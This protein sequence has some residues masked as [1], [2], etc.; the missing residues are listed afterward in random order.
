MTTEKSFAGTTEVK[1]FPTGVDWINTSQP[2]S[3]KDL[4]GKIVILD[5]WT[6]CCINCM[7]IIPQLR[8][9]EKRFVEELVVLGI[10]S[11]K[12]PQEKE[13]QNLRKAVLRLG[14]PHPVMNDRDF[15][16]W[17]S[18]GLRS[19][20]TL[21]FIDPQGKI[22]GIH[23]GEI[24]AVGLGAV[25]KDM[26]AEFDQKGWVDRKPLPFQLERPELGPLSFPG[27]VLADEKSNRLFI[28]DSNHHQIVVADLDGQVLSVAGSGDFGMLDGLFAEATF[29]APQ[30]MAL[31]GQD[32]YVADNENH[33]IRK[34]D[35]VAKTV[36]TV[37][38]VGS[39]A[40]Q[41]SDGGDALE[42]ALSSPWDLAH[43]DGML[44]IAMAG[45]HQIWVLDLKKKKILP[46]AGSGAEGL[47]DGPLANAKMAQPSGLSIH[48]DIMYV[49]D[50][51]TSS[52]RAVEL[53]LDGF[54][55]TIV[56]SDLFAFGDVDGMG[57]IVK[58]QH[59]LGVC[60]YQ[61]I[62]YLADTFNSKIKR[63]F[64][65]TKS[66]MAYLGAGKP[67]KQDGPGALASF[68]EPGGLSAAHGKLY[69]ADTNNH[70]IRVADLATSTVSTLEIKGLE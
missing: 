59:P 49:A 36:E 41:H 45:F 52:V 2:V 68:H 51:E 19:W 46:F 4:R 50:S 16:V 53:R 58:L 66:S 13:T 31:V 7:H 65:R 10:H 32:L 14:I 15:R 5:F 8:I 43:K 25:I 67:G 26:I 11:P 1:E 18:Y 39:Q 60:S 56:G 29:N 12:F 47:G 30:G 37:A 33:T 70:L 63:V 38:G 27:K 9:L 21:M 55:R 64:P 24:T 57:E 54:V 61:D 22:M 17:R 3:L 23:E 28:A 40:F 6:Y 34:L 35:L 42:T 48:G 69:I 62:L 44:Y 20:P